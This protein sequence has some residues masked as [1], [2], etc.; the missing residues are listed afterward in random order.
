MDQIARREEGFDLEAGV[1]L[2]EELARV[3][4]VS[5]AMLARSF[6]TK[7]CKG[8]DDADRTIKVEAGLCLSNINRASAE[9]VI[10]PL[11]IKVQVEGAANPAENQTGKE[12][13]KV[14]KTKKCCK[15]PRPPRG[16]TL[17]ASDHKLVKEIAELAILKR[18]RIERM[19]KL[20]ASKESSSGLS[21]SGSMFSMLFTIIFCLVIL[22]QGRYQ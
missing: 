8:L 16:L 15:P 20:K 19:K 2:S 18:A 17:N 22:F 10:L 9:K 14:A 6:F 11:D 7:L 13:R 5:G 1:I 3:E 12:K 4:T 21:S